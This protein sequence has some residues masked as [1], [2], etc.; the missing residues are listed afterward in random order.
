MDLRNG[1]CIEVMKT[2]DDNSVDMLFADLPYNCINAH[3]DC[4]IPLDEFWAEV[5]R[6]TKKNTPV[7]LTC[8]TRFGYELIKSN[9][10][11]FRYDLVWRKSKPVG[12]LNARKQPMRL[13][14]M[15]YVFGKN[16]T[17]Y[18]ISSHK[19]VV[20][21]TAAQL[22]KEA[23]DK[24]YGKNYASVSIKYDPPLPKSVLDIE[25]VKKI[26][27]DDESCYGDVEKKMDWD[28]KNPQCQRTY[29]PP[30][31]KSVIE[32]ADRQQYTYGLDSKKIAF[33]KDK[34]SKGVISYDPPL[35]KSV[36]E[37]DLCRSKK[38]EHKEEVE[39]CYPTEKY[40]P[41]RAERGEI[42]YDPPL[43]RSIVEVDSYRL[44]AHSTAKPPDLMRWILKY[45][46]KEGDVVLDP[47]MGSN[48]MGLVC[49]EMDRKFIGIEKD[50]EIFD[51]ACRRVNFKVSD[52]ENIL[53]EIKSI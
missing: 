10:K 11:W 33:N 18:D 7:I 50:S 5:Q 52:D 32:S 42:S 48:P 45:Y 17:Y 37:D 15:V 53:K 1:D 39:Q 20:T 31:P 19:Q 23:S 29:V 36:I 12:H 46:T 8:T 30:L 3:W 40:R 35:P 25:S 44:K 41:G 2:L 43:P 16:C 26:K 14:E 27:A 6:I 13:H 28:K 49:K 38:G 47:T 4:K 51:F 24:V 22:K 9:P 34:K 21:K